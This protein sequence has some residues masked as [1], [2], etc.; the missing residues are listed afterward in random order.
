MHY[1]TPAGKILVQT[2][3]YGDKTFPGYFH[4]KMNKMFQGFEFIRVY[5]YDLLLNMISDWYDC[6]EKLELTLNELKE[7][8]IKFNIKKLFL[9]PNQNGVFGFWG[10]MSKC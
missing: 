7:N 1:Y 3:T 2:T 10:D 6:L 8:G 9:R 4:E 5:I